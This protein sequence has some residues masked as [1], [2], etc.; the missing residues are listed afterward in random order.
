MRSVAKTEMGLMLMPE[1]S[2]M[3]TPLNLSDH[4]SDLSGLKRSHLELDA[5]V[6][7]LGVL[8]DHNHVSL[9]VARAHSLVIAARAHA[10]VQVQLLAKG[11]VNAAEAPSDRSSDGALDGDFRALD[12]LDHVV[13]KGRALL[14]QHV[15]PRVHDFPLDRNARGLNAL[16]HGRADFRPRTVA[17]NESN[18][19]HE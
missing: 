12:R 8:A 10:G 15:N 17:G 16:P 14:L 6:E 11:H 19:V 1:S 13:G 4:I 7:I 18:L 9:R 5:S 2:R 3:R